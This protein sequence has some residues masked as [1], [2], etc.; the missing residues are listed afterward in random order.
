MLPVG[1]FI[2]ADQHAPQGALMTMVV[3]TSLVFLR[4][5]RV[6]L[7][8]GDIPGLYGCRFS[9][10]I[11]K[12]PTADAAAH[13]V[14]RSRFSATEPQWPRTNSTVSRSLRTH[15]SRVILKIRLRA[16]RL[17]R[18]RPSSLPRFAASDDGHFA[19]G[20]P[21]ARPTGLSCCS[22][23]RCLFTVNGSGER[24]KRGGSREGA[25]LFQWN[26][27]SSRRWSNALYIGIWLAPLQR[28][29][30]HDPKKD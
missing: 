14:V 29:G 4:Q 17:L 24:A 12:G 2:D 7:R 6:R 27:C 13:C 21:P 23:N 28:S 1:A 18:F 19:P 10:S 22:H 20:E 8:L 30:R 25:K 3:F 11:E 26:N 9:D 15:D 16:L 5:C